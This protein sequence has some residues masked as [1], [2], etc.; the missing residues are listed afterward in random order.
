MSHDPLSG[1]STSYCDLWRK[2][3]DPGDWSSQSDTL[4]L[5]ESGL[6]SYDRGNRGMNSSPQ[7]TV[8]LIHTALL[9]DYR[10]NI[11]VAT[12]HLINGNW[13]LPDSAHK[14][15]CP[16]PCP[17]HRPSGRV[18]RRGRRF[19]TAPPRQHHEAHHSHPPHRGGAGASARPAP[20][21]LV[22]PALV[23]ARAPAASDRRVPDRARVRHWVCPRRRSRAPPS[24][25]CRG[26]ASRALA[27]GLSRGSPR[28]R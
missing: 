6:L 23:R 4:P 12:P 17:S 10:S 19:L 3:N 7:G 16:M 27:R 8:L 25:A 13:E 18:A 5:I 22:R 28:G 24:A 2:G 15:Q 20:A 11:A 26:R 9:L 1:S 14:A 21:D